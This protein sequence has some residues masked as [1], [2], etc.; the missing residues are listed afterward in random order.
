MA[1]RGRKPNT[2]EDRKARGNP[3]KRPLTTLVPQP[4]K[5]A[6]LVPREVEANDRA[7]GYWEMFLTNSAP[8]HLR[9]LDAPL[10]ARLCLALAMADQASEEVAKTGLLVKS[11]TGIP[12]QN[13]YLPILNKQTE[14]ARKLA[15]EL[16]LPPAMRNRIGKYGDDEKT[17]NDPWDDLDS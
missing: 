12:M 1:I 5:G 11:K 14:I 7:Q 10:L 9:P 8:G 4:M 17:E 16:A 6:M 13:P 15:T 3:S 2:I